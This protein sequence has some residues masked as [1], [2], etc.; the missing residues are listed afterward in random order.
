M[1]KEKIIKQTKNELLVLL[2]AIINFVIFAAC[3]TMTHISQVPVVRNSDYA[4]TEDSTVVLKSRATDRLGKTGNAVIIE[5]DR[6]AGAIII[7]QAEKG[8]YV[9]ASDLS[10]RCEKVLSYN[11]IN[12]HFICSSPEPSE[13]DITG[14]VIS[15]PAEK[16]LKIYDIFV[17]DGNLIF[18]M[19]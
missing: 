19:K 5:D 9:A 7:V 13:F 18:S 17:K 10:A 4:V 16:P 2:P 6:L 12:K 8:K 11:G 1:N 15:G 3:A 14:K